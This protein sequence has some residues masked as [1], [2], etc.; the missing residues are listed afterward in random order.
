MLKA[1]SLTNFV[2]SDLAKLNIM[3][4]GSAMYPDGFHPSNMN[5]DPSNQNEAKYITRRAVHG[6]KYYITDFGISTKFS[7]GESHFVT[8]STA[9]DSDVPELSETVPYDA[10]SVD[11]FTLGNVFKKTLIEV[12]YTYLCLCYYVD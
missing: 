5:W 3:M 1:T 11:V 8:G 9:L 10:F 12:R 4:D 7:E 6:V 2:Y